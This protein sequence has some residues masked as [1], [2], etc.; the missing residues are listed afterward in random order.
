MVVESIGDLS[1]LSC[2]LGESSTTPQT[3]TRK[4]CE[5]WTGPLCPVSKGPG[6]LLILE[7]LINHSS[8]LPKQNLSAERASHVELQS[9]VT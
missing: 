4:M 3:R 9:L 8:H 7:C 5:H 1:W 2:A 6:W